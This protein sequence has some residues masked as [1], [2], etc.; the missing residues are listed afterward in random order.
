MNYFGNILIYLKRG[1]RSSDALWALKK[2]QTKF[3]FIQRIKWTAEVKFL[4]R[5]RIE[6]NEQHFLFLLALLAKCY[7]QSADS[8]IQ[9]QERQ[10]K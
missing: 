7:F 6:C 3:I 4:F 1:V 2:Q 5:T 10:F 8:E 9:L